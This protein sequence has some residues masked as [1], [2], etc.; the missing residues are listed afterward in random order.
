MNFTGTPATNIITR[1]IGTKMIADPRS[2]SAMINTNG[3][4][5]IARA[6]MKLIGM[7]NSSTGRLK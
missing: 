1:P 5:I 3:S 2:G 7:R 6:L 4:A